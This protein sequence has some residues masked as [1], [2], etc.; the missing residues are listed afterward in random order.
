MEACRAFKPSL[1]PRSSVISSL[2]PAPVS[3]SNRQAV[4]GGG[5]PAEGGVRVPGGI[6]H[7]GGADREWQPRCHGLGL[8][9][10]VASE[11]LQ[12]KHDT[13]GRVCLEITLIRSRLPVMQK[14]YNVAPMLDHVLTWDRSL[15]N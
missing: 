6:L 9:G 12:L 7:G 2:L 11:K 14:I 1:T 15:N 3:L 13:Y 8:W 4:D 10:G 5:A